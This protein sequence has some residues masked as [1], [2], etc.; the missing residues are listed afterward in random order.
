MDKWEKL[1]AGLFGSFF[2][3]VFL[4]GVSLFALFGWGFIEIVTWL[5]S[6]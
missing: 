3:F 1:G 4:L 2:V 6:K 5:T